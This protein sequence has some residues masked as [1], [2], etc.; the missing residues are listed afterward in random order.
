MTPASSID[1]AGKGAATPPSEQSRFQTLKEALA[2]KINNPW[3]KKAAAIG[4]LSTLY[5]AL[6]TA[7]PQALIMGTFIGNKVAN[8]DDLQ[9]ELTKNRQEADRLYREAIDPLLDELIADLRSLSTFSERQQV[10]A[11]LL[12]RLSEE[13]NP[14]LKSLDSDGFLLQDIE[15]SIAMRHLLPF[16]HNAPLDQKSEIATRFIEGVN[17]EAPLLA[18][19]LK[20]KQ[21]HKSSSFLID[22]LYQAAVCALIIK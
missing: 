5:F 19:T 1:Q 7:F 4:S 11:E 17:R 18:T 12:T 13:I 3:L 8:W 9:T 16:Q 14:T 20:M 6:S 22:S 21:D 10:V 2:N 15:I